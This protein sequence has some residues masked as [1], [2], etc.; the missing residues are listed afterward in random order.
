VG[1]AV[2][3]VRHTLVSHN[4]KATTPQQGRQQE[5]D[6]HQAMLLQQRA[7]LA[8]QGQ[9]GRLEQEGKSPQPLHRV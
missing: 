8:Q 1:E 5:V 3:G 6:L 7:S 2:E 4:N 9:E